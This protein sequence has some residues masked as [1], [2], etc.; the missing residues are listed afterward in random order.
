MN[1]YSY[2]VKYLNI[3]NTKTEKKYNLRKNNDFL[4]NF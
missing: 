3:F 2:I 1:I 4:K